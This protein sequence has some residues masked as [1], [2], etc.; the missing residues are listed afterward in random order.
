MCQFELQEDKK[1]AA[2]APTLA[3]YL[4]LI[5]QSVVLII[6]TIGH[7]KAPIETLQALWVINYV[8]A[9]LMSYFGQRC[10]TASQKWA[11]A[12]WL[13]SMTMCICIRLCVRSWNV[14]MANNV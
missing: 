3:S 1:S 5:I 10:F 7:K 6:K 2:F 12:R 9:E 4:A 14:F 13:L 11:Y 8:V